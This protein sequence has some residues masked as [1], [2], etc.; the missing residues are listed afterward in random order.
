M[1]A[2]VALE[3]ARVVFRTTS[4]ETHALD[5]VDL[6][7]AP[8]EFVTIQGRSGS[9]KSTLLGVLGLLAPL[10]EGRLALFGEDTAELDARQRARLRR[11]KIGF[12]F[13]AF[14][15]LPE[16]S[17]EENIALP[18]IYDGRPAAAIAAR[19]GELAAIFGLESRLGH[20][21][22]QLSGGQQQRVAIARALANDAPLLLVDE[23]T[24]NLDEENAA[25]VLD[26]LSQ[27]HREGR[28]ICLVTH[29][30]ASA[31]RG[32]RRLQMR[33]GRLVDPGQRAC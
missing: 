16:L 13:Q 28:T 21:P 31:A 4:I 32:S 24:G 17:V 5:G 12:V 20:F 8:G 29:D 30:P 33:D 22:A 19:V 7:I 11:Q 9:G 10:A 6:S 26:T 14:H 23:P 27:L 18:M 25:I 3:G 2:A 1:S 15:L